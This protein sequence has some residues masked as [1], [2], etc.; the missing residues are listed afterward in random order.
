MSIRH[1]TRLYIEELFSKIRQD[2]GEYTLYNI[3]L[4][5]DVQEPEDISIVDV[6]VDFSDQESIKKYLD[7]TT[8][9]TLEGEVKGLKLLGIVLEKGGDYI[10]SSKEQLGEKFKEEVIKMIERIKEE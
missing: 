4:P 6:Q 8:R 1:Q 10:F 2:S 3:Y 9:E 5:R 7:R